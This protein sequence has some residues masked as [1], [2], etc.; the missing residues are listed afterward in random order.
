MNTKYRI[1]QT[2]IFNQDK[3]I[4]GEFYIPDLKSFPLVIICHGFG[5][6]HNGTKDLAEVF[7]LNGI[8]AF[9]FDFCGGS[10]DSLSDGK[11]TE[12]SVL[13]EADDLFAVLDEMKK[14]LLVDKDKIFLVGK[15][16]GGYVT[17]FVAAHRVEEIAGMALWYPAYVIEDDAQERLDKYPPFIDEMDVMGTKIS[18]KYNLDAVS[19]NIY[20][21]MRLFYKDVL[22]I[23]G[24][25]DSIVPVSYAQEAA[26]TFPNAKLIT[27]ERAEHGF[28]G[29]ERPN[30]IRMTFDFINDHLERR[31]I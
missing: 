10:N 23:H 30:V 7:A 14:N 3:K 12:M 31:I 6:T 25:A 17:T 2:D 8:G 24:T 26:E 13:T 9:I 21:W 29:L 22:I 28:H 15:S 27:I 20:T 16:Q 18:R 11:T 4:Y 1:E 5:E 19:A